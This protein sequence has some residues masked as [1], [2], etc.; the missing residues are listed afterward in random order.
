MGRPGSRRA[1]EVGRQIPGHPP[2][3]EDRRTVRRST[4]G[5]RTAGFAPGPARGVRERRGHRCQG[6]GLAGIAGPQE[7]VPRVEIG[8]DGVDQARDREHPRDAGGV[9]RPAC[10]VAG[11]RTPETVTGPVG[12]AA[13]GVS[14]D[15]RTTMIAD[16]LAVSS[17]SRPHTV[18]GHPEDGG[19]RSGPRPDRCRS[20]APDGSRRRTR[21]P[22]P[23]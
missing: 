23:A 16:P 8:P 19:R 14:L 12:T 2:P 21:R 6:R 20:P 7:H 18:R 22:D 13:L 4:T 9:R 17:G 11:S 15:P 5:R 10:L 3:H 1:L